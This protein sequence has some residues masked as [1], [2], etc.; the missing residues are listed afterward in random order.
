M[1]KK[2]G[3]RSV[4]ALVDELV[5]EASRLERAKKSETEPGQIGLG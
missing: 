5:Q 2:R 1:R 4:S 3:A